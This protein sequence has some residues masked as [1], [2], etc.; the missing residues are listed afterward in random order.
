[1]LDMIGQEECIQATED[2][3]KGKDPSKAKR[4][5]KD[6]SIMGSMASTYSKDDA[7]DDHKDLDQKLQK[8]KFGDKCERMKGLSDRHIYY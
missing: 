5:F 7:E 6:I 4:M 2:Q 3:E 1:M 8:E